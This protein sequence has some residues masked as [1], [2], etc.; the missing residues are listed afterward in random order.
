MPDRSLGEIAE[1]MRD[2]DFAMLSTRAENDAIAAR[3]MSTNRDVAYDGDSYFFTWAGSHMVADITRDA[4]VGLSF[5][6]KAGIFG[7]RPF[8]VSVEGDAEI[9]RDKARFAEH[10]TKDLDRWFEQGPDTPG[11]AMIKVHATRIHYW[12]GE[13]EG[14]VLLTAAGAAA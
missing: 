5:Q 11:I 6:G 2:I 10:W 3:P 1:K 4:R 13:D 8:F 12:D 14:E 7:Q 9:I